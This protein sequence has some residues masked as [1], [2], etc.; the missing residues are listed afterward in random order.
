MSLTQQLLFFAC[1]GIACVVQN[2][3]GFAFGLVLLGLV[4][5][6]HLASLPDAA[7]VVSVLILANAVFVFRGR[8]PR[9]P[10][11]LFL[12]TLACSL[13]GVAGGVWLLAHLS[14]GATDGLRL[15]LGLAILVSA[16]LLIRTRQAA[17]SRSGIGAYLFY[18]ALSGT[19]G[20]LFSSAGPPLVYHMYRQPL[21]AAVIKDF[22]TLL[23]AI[24]AVFRLTLVVSSNRFSAEAGQ[25]SLVAAPLVVAITLWMQKQARPATP[26]KVKW[27]VFI[28]LLFAAISLIVQAVQALYLS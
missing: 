23:F 2:L 18:G 4:A 27:L 16:F 12:P 5:M 6:F 14:A 8:A 13:I 9:V 28:L 10:W 25:L 3:T 22:L 21:D 7:N 20:G 17:A 24:N 15:L 1:T 26:A 11:S 19:T